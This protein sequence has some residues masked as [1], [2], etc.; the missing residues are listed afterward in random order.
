MK[1]TKQDDWENVFDDE[2]FN[3]GNI[4]NTNPEG[5][6]WKEIW[7]ETERVKKFICSQRRQAILE[8]IEAIRSDENEANVFVLANQEAKIAELKKKE[9]IK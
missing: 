6:T 8:T 1:K 7:K 2:Y 3:Y 4:W 5:M 9:G